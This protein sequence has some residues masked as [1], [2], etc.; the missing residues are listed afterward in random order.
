MC[1]KHG[2][3]GEAVVQAE[4][5]KRDFSVAFFI[6]QST[7]DII[8]AWDDKVLQRIQVKSAKGEYTHNKINEH[9]CRLR[10]T[11]KRHGN[12][13]HFYDKGSLDYFVFVPLYLDPIP[14]YVIP[15]HQV[16]QVQTVDI[17]PFNNK[18][19]YNKFINQWDQLKTPASD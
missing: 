2:D 6:G 10:P 3:L 8:S 16:P 15:F 7:I 17:K 18:C 5:I 11:R 19:P 14:F 13:C 4:L 12:K 9:I 1:E